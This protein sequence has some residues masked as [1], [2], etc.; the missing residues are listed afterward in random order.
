[1]KVTMLL[2]DSAQAVEGKLYILGGGW[3]VIGPEPLS[4]A[5]ALKIDV[6]WDQSNRR[7]KF[8]FTL[9]DGDGNPVLIRPAPEA[10]AQAIQIGGEFEVGRPPGVLP[11]TPLDASAAINI[12]PLPLPQGGRYVWELKINGRTEEDWRLPFTT[13][14]MPVQLA[15]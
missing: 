12:G 4:S 10:P 2:A 5:I 14:P 1:V 13:R 3:S 15:S 8:E 9:L 11:G 6:P 7:H